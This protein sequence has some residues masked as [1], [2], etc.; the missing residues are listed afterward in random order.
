MS[1]DAPRLALAGLRIGVTSHRRAEDL[2]TAL[3]RQGAEV[4]HAAT[5]Q[6]VPV[7]DDAELIA[8][9]ERML[10]ADPRVLLVTTG[11]GFRD[12]LAALPSPLRDRTEVQIRSSR[13]FCR[14]AKARGA[15]A[16]AGFG[17]WPAAPGETTQSL[18]DLALQ[19]G[20]AHEPVALQRHGWLDP[21]Q[22]ERLRAAGC[23]LHVVQPYRWVPGPDPAAVDALIDEVLADRLDALTFTAA[24]AV[25]AL[26]EAADR[27]GLRGDLLEA[28]RS[29][30]CR[31]VAVGHVT[32]QP[33]Q[34]AGITPITPERERMGAMVKRMIEVLGAPG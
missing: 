28:L 23:S 24:P 31:A 22:V 25:D 2:I 20:V 6:I 16:G 26:G 12:W 27:R 1:P 17:S 34:A 29:G 9:T 19:A 10:A 5:M 14:G 32:A 4:L 3:E 13:L 7:E 11:Q 30:R 8:E 18:V 15:V 21:V 33:L